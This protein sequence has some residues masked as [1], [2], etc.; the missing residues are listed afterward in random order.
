VGSVAEGRGKKKKIILLLP[1]LLFFK[2]KVLLI[3]ILLGVLF[4]KKLLI[5]GAVLL[6]SLLHMIKFCK[7]FHGHGHSVWNSGPDIAAEYSTGYGH[8]GPYHGDYHG[9]RSMKW[10]PQSLAYRGY[11][12]PNQE[13]S[14][15]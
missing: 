8:S 6:P 9:R 14:G 12:T 11:N 4:I 3:P 7:P 15:V 2:L 5:L 13:R 10:N 1:L